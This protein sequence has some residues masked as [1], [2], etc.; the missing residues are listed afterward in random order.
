[1]KIFYFSD[2][3][4]ELAPAWAM[5]ADLPAFDVAVAAG[6]IAGSPATAIDWLA[7]LP[8]FQGKPVVYVHGNHEHYRG[9]VEDRL[10][11]G[12]ATARR[13]GIHFLNASTVILD[14]VRFAGAALW[15][16]FALYGDREWALHAAGTGMNDYR[17]IRRRA[18]T[19][20]QKGRFR[21]K[22]KDTAWYH[23]HQRSFIADMLA[24]PFDGPTVVVTHHAPSARSLP[25]L[26]RDDQL[27]DPA[28]ASDLE[29]MILARGPDLWIHGHIHQSVD[30]RVGRTRVVSNPKGYGPGL[31][32]LPSENR[33]FDPRR[34]VE[35][36][37]RGGQ[38][39]R[40]ARG[41]ASGARSAL[42]AM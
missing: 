13:T 39:P 41:V 10:E 21:L 23:A 5:P 29:A 15:T 36:L 17:L 33:F 4:L 35:V 9:V 16:D 2:L 6:D 14:G 8:A 40:A 20:G 19:P 1:M 26:P 3:H 37:H 18:C 7:A 24:T 38:K 25:P 28:Y 32:S 34:I 30:Y 12:L 42:G 11:E 27:L 31:K 22:P